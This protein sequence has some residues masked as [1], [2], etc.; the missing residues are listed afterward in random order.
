MLLRYVKWDNIRLI[1]GLLLACV[2]G[3]S[4]SSSIPGADPT[5]SNRGG[6]KYL[7][8]AS[9]SHHERKARYGH[10]PGLAKDGPRLIL[11]ATWPRRPAGTTIAFQFR[12][13]KRQRFSYVRIWNVFAVTRW[14]ARP[15]Y[16]QNQL[17]T[18]LI[19]GLGSFRVLDALSCN[20][21]LTLK[22]S[23]INWIKK[24]ADQ[25]LEGARAC[26]A[27]AWIRLDHPAVLWGGGG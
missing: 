24:M 23:N 2:Y 21:T 4:W 10:G 18:V 25:S 15:S 6:L 22:H 17:R 7:I 11:C 13:S 1:K 12:T 8:F 5:V 19:K 14:P 20:L 27:S 26:C 16:A 9:S 3:Q